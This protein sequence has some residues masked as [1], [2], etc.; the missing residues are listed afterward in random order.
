MARTGTSS[1]VHNRSIVTCLWLRAHPPPQDQFL[2][3]GTNTRTDKY[4]GS[5]E[6]RCRFLDEV[7][8]AVCAAV[9]PQRVLLRLSPHYNGNGFHQ[10]ADEDPLGL[11]SAA[12]A[13]ADRHGVAALFLTEPRWD[14]ALA[15]GRD[16]PWARLPCVNSELF[17]PLFRGPLL[18]ATGFTPASAREAV[19]R[20]AYDAVA[21]GRWF[22]SNPDLPLRARMGF[23]LNTPDRATFY[24][25]VPDARGYTDYPCWRAV[26]AHVLRWARV[27][28]NAPHPL[29]SRVAHAVRLGSEGRPEPLSA[30]LAEELVAV[31]R[32]SGLQYPLLA[33]AELAHTTSS[34][35]R[36][37]RAAYM[38]TVAAGHALPR[39]VDSDGLSAS[40]A[41]A[42]EQ[43]AGHRGHVARR[44]TDISVAPLARDERIRG[45]QKQG[46]PDDAESKRDFHEPA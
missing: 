11:Y 34:Q 33:Q 32:H 8:T 27:H 17:R 29:W 20:G 45:H 31:S 9:G 38:A 6:N 25:A 15:P 5:V 36:A 19:A 42:A 46:Q 10:V 18:G 26:C 41:P 7:L 22:I 3:S 4:G 39:W 12:V 23:P 16:D 21:L 44:Y 2:N 1:Y 35:E 37:A 28:G 24:E 30:G 40:E 13:V 43:P 14:R